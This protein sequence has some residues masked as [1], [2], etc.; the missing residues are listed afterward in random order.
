MLSKIEVKPKPEPQTPKQM[1]SMAK[2]LTA[3]F[4]GKIVEN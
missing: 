2:L 4:G 1:M 3:A